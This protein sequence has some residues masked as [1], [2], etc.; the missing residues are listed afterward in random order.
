MAVFEF[1][2]FRRPQVQSY[3][4]PLQF[5]LDEIEVKTELSKEII[6][7]DNAIELS[8]K[9]VLSALDDQGKMRSYYLR[10]K[11]YKQ[12]QR[13]IIDIKLAN[14]TK[15]E[16]N[17]K[18]VQTVTVPAGDPTDYSSFEIVITPND[19]FVY[20]RVHFLLARELEDF[21]TKNEKGYYGRLVKMEVERLDEIY[22]VINTINAAINN[23]GVLKQIGVQS[24]PG[25]LMSINGEAIK[26][27][28]SGLYEI[29]N[30]VPV[31]F[32]GFILDEDDER[33]FILDYQY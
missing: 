32:I 25:L 12:E 11:V 4:T 18:I 29:K 30:G 33:Y 1:G 19:D 27:G 3:L 16:D 13:Q 15:D 10:F 2:Q 8:G 28:R 20:N 6:F 17:E 7:L 26:V 23:K 14:T 9:N 5:D 21:N 22:N 31:T 24:A